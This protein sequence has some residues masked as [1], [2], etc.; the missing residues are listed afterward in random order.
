MT[1][2]DPNPGG[3]DEP[4]TGNTRP[5]PSGPPNRTALL[6]VVI[7]LIIMVIGSNIA[8][9]FGL[10]FVTERPVLVMVLSSQIKWLVLAV[11][12]VDPVVFFTVGM[13][14]NLAP[15]PFFYILGFW[16]GDAAVR[17]MEHRVPSMGELLRQAER[18][19][20]KWGRPLV[21][22]FPNNPICLLAGA[23]RMPVVEFA[24][25][26]VVGTAGRLVLIKIFGEAFE[27]PIQWFLDLLQEY[28]IPLLVIGG[29]AFVF[30][31]WNENRKGTGEVRALVE[32]EEEFDPTHPA[33]LH[34]ETPS[35]R[36]D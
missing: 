18:H 11:N 33:E 32:L 21:L 10:G 26:N 7:P 34:D 6:A 30:T 35:D 15:D 19:F 20:P 17:W 8:N 3:D 1:S 9:Y 13:L 14:R 29:L 24:V 36:E 27:T 25:L 16:Y 12:L 5:A 22:L 23:A 28:R 31:I 2:E 4:V